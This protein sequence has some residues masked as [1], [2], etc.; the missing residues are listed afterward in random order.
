[1]TLKLLVVVLVFGVGV[2]PNPKIPCQVF[3]PGVNI[4]IG[5]LLVDQVRYLNFITPELNGRP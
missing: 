3:T 2:Y 4:I 1:V 5:A